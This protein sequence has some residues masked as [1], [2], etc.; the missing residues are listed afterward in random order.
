MI[1]IMV[2]TNKN[3]LPCGTLPVATEEVECPACGYFEYLSLLTI[4]ELIMQDAR[5]LTQN[6]NYE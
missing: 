5:I 6:K 3:F 2:S 4:F 1:Q